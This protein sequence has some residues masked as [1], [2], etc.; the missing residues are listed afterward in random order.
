MGPIVWLV[1][2]M[3]VLKASDAMSCG[4]NLLIFR[5]ILAEVITFL[6]TCHSL[7]LGVR[8][9][10]MQWRMLLTHAK[11]VLAMT[12]VI[13][14]AILAAAAICLVVGAA[15][16]SK[17][18]ITPALS[19][20][21]G[22]TTN[23]GPQTV[24]FEFLVNSNISVNALGLDFAGA[25][26]T[27][28]VGLWTTG[29]TLLAST[30]VSSSDTLVGNF[31]YASITPVALT[32]GLDYIVGGVDGSNGF[33]YDT[34]ATTDPRISYVANEFTA[35]NTGFGFPTYSQSPS[36]DDGY[37]GGSF[38]IGSSVVSTPEPST[39]LVAL[40]GSLAGTAYLWRRRRMVAA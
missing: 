18:D 38:S 8:K 11:E 32:A 30:T 4:T 6:R 20:T 5:Y 29:G 26:G 28:E 31:N 7:T 2:F 1:K 16:R 3:G 15:G 14:K 22:V 40:V 13:R 35:P 12:A 34:T 17:A 37:F 21:G 19:Y 33:Y 24:G 27:S 23:N 25:T 10:R 39:M 36:F 9:Q